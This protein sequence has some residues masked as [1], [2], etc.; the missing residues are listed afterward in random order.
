VVYE[1][2]LQMLCDNPS[3]YKKEPECMEF[4]SAVPAVWDETKVLNAKI[5]DYIT[6]ARRTGEEWYIGAMTDW[7]SRNLSFDLSFLAEGKYKMTLYRDGKNAD[8]NAID[9]KKVVKIVDSTNKINIHL[10]PGGGW[11]ARLVPLK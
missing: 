6:V 4:L 2:P 10:A 7:D 3:N 11:V 5:S 1:S 8:R 9:Y